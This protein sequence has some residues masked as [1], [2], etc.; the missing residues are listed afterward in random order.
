MVKY[1][2]GWIF[3][4]PDGQVVSI[5]DAVAF[6]NGYPPLMVIYID[7]ANNLMYCEE[8]L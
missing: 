8:Y 2:K 6:I 1:N 5:G 7:G 4:I 3:P